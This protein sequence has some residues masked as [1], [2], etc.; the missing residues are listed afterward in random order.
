MC[1]ELFLVDTSFEEFFSGDKP[2]L[3]NA[4]IEGKVSISQYGSILPNKSRCCII[5]SLSLISMHTECQQNG[6]LDC[7]VNIHVKINLLVLAIRIY[8]K[9][10]CHL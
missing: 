10:F 7:R 4:H 3:C 8:I 6:F 9:R 5:K 2:F 1:P